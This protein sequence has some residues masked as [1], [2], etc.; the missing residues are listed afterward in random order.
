MMILVSEDVNWVAWKF[1][2]GYFA[3]GLTVEYRN[4]LRA[5]AANF[6][7]DNPYTPVEKTR[8]QCLAKYFARYVGYEDFLQSHKDG[9]LKIA[10]S[11]GIAQ[12]EMYH[13]YIVALLDYV[14]AEE[15]PE[16]QNFYDAKYSDEQLLN[17]AYRFAIGF[18]S[19]GALFSPREIDVFRSLILKK[20]KS[21]FE[22][23]DILNMLIE[24]ADDEMDFDHF[25]DSRDYLLE[26][27]IL[28]GLTEG[29]TFKYYKVFFA[30]VMYKL[31]AD[32]LVDLKH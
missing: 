28:G 17:F 31:A 16:S 29:E 30:H 1:I 23:E 11:Q 15:Y 14:L 18:F 25:K 3:S 12:M 7:I 8:A 22:N 24:W 4:V 19:A 6:K 9:L 10:A 5:W 21:Q 32:R 2:R 26:A 20:R 27:G 13:L